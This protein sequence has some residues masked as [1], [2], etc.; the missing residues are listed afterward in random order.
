VFTP[1]YN[2]GTSS[3]FVTAS[4]SAEFIPEPSII[5]LFAVGLLG[6]GYAG[7]RKQV[8]S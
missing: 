3:L 5:G 7:R 8:K 6:L 2:P 1:E 4:W